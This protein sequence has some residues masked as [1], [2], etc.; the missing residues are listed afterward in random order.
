MQDGQ[1]GNLVEELTLDGFS[2]ETGRHMTPFFAGR[3]EM[4][5]EAR[6]RRDQVFRKVRNGVR[7][8]AEGV[9]LL[10][11]GAPGAGKTSLLSKLEECLDVP[12]VGLEVKDLSDPEAILKK[13]ERALATAG[14]PD[15]P[16]RLMDA[17]GGI[18]VS[19]FGTDISLNPSK[20]LEAVGI[21]TKGCAI[22]VFIDEIQNV[23]PDNRQAVECLQTLH[24]G[25]HGF[26][27][28][29]VLAGLGNSRDVLVKVG[30]SRIDPPDGISVGRLTPGEAR[31]SVESFMRYFDVRGETGPWVEDVVRRSDLWPQH[32]HNGLRA[33][34][35][36]LFEC[37]GNLDLVDSRRLERN[38]ETLRKDAYD[39]RL[40]SDIRR[41][42]RLVASLMSEMR[43]RD[44]GLAE[45]E[46]HIEKNAQDSVGWRLPKNVDADGFRQHLIHKGVLQERSGDICFCPIPSFQTFLIGYGQENPQLVD[47]KDRTLKP[48]RTRPGSSIPRLSGTLSVRTE[49]IRNRRWRND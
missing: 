37:G 44:F 32:L 17:V 46:D 35:G 7:N 8:P 11:Q 47:M 45:V 1:T 26:P 30:I 5:E 10:F 36:E 40:S 14:M 18:S 41:A 13:T 20:I 34:A 6:Q 33:L 19:V 31:E 24:E 2:H 23:D 21:V 16:K 15:V 3:K 4:I 28:L 12:C 9:T 27:V 49:D 38:R 22:A 48:C 39:G 29:P 25:R 43:K 42:K